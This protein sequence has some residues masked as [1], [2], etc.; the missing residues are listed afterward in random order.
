MI[1]Q[2]RKHDRFLTERNA[3][4][5]L[6]GGLTQ[7]V[8]IKDISKGGMAFEYIFHKD[9]KQEPFKYVD[10]FVSA[11]EFY[12]YNVPFKIIYDKPL[13]AHNTNNIFSSP[14]GKKRCGLQFKTLQEEQSVQLATL[15][16]EYTKGMIASKA[17]MTNQA[18]SC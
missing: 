7:S 14:F 16:K 3:L 18:I 1:S 13:C 2:Q 10:I 6:R 5:V 8:R 11:K 12:L 15:L 9:S 4:V 17:T